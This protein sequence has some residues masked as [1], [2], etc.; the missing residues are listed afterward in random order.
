MR[1]KENL[2]P[3]KSPDGNLLGSTAHTPYIRKVLPSGSFTL[4]SHCLMPNHFHMEIRQ[5]T[6]I[7]ISKLITKVCTSYGKYFNKKY[8]RVG[9]LFQD[10]FKAVLL[11]SESYMLWLSAYIHNNPKTAG[12]VDELSDYAWS[13]YPDY[14]GIRKGTLCDKDIILSHFKDTAS[15]SNFVSEAAIKIRDMKDIQDSLIDE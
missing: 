12:M 10:A 14:I 13:S 7:P 9:G 4:L 6:N 1:L 2:F 15:Y 11:E 3:H 5:N 8:N